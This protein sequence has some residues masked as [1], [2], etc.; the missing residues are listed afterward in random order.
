[1]GGVPRKQRIG[2]GEGERRRGKRRSGASK[3][4]SRE[5]FG[6]GLA[7]ART[8]VPPTFVGPTNVGGYRKRRMARQRR[9]NFAALPFSSAA[10]S[11]A[12]VEEEEQGISQLSLQLVQPLPLD[13]RSPI[14][15]AKRLRFLFQ[16]EL[17]RTDA[18]TLGRIV[19]PKI[20]FNTSQKT[21]ENSFQRAAEAYL[22]P[23]SYK[24]GMYMCMDDMDGLQVWSF[25]YRFWPNNNSRMYVLEN[26]GEFVRVHG[27]RAGDFVML[28]K[29]DQNEKYII[30]AR[31][32]SEKSSFCDHKRL[33]LYDANVLL[34]PDPEVQKPS[35]FNL[36]IP[37][38]DDISTS[39]FFET[40]LIDEYGMEF[41]KLDPLLEFG[42]I[43]N[44][45]L[46]DFP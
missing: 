21:C 33:D 13:V 5:G 31:K 27:L 36:N 26:T 41:P 28:Y 32:A 7:L 29:D 4:R 20:I 40:N 30:R 19:L 18:G 2:K 9:I 34:I 35:Y 1:M 17:R 38:G 25:K 22:P 39:L 43:D 12:R 24:D 45:Y 10:S 11:A 6:I 46:D 44:L 3:S 16:K 23:L 14:V 37:I 15:D 8:L 42:S